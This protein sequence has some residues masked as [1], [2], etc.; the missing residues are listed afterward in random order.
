MKTP[1][2]FET[3][4]LAYGFLSDNRSH[5]FSIILPL[6][7][8][9]YLNNLGGAV[10]NVIANT[11]IALPAGFAFFNLVTFIMA[12]I[13]SLA[14][15]AAWHRAA[16]LGVSEKNRMRL[17][18]LTSGDRNFIWAMIKLTFVLLAFA[19]VYVLAIL[20]SEAILE[21]L[22]IL[23][24][25]G[26]AFCLLY[27]G[28]RLYLYIPAKAVNADVT[29]REAMEGSKGIALKIIFALIFAAIPVVL[30]SAIC[31]GIVGGII[32]VFVYPLAH[33]NDALLF[34]LGISI[35]STFFQ[36][37]ATAISVTVISRYYLWAVQERV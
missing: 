25:I 30:V 32:G 6:L 11:E 18:A 1:G 9:L 35:P 15:I 34:S 8:F 33:F 7:P 22:S 31:G 23:T 26:G 16:I 13:C 4:K 27:F 17:T 29:M 21:P 5:F 14:L 2:I 36:A 24:V 20:I 19:A 10:Q 12:A 37:I 3:V 28:V